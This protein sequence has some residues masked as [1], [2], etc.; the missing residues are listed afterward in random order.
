M[1]TLRLINPNNPPNPPRLGD[2]L[3]RVHEHRDDLR[4]IIVTGSCVDRMGRLA[5]GIEER[6]EEFGYVIE[7]ETF[8]RVGYD[9]ARCPNLNHL[10]FQDMD[11]G[12]DE[13]RGIWQEIHHGRFVKEITFKEMNL[14]ANAEVA[15]RLSTTGNATKVHFVSCVIER[16]IAHCMSDYIDRLE[17]RNKNWR[18]SLVVVR[19][20][21][22][23][24]SMLRYNMNGN[25]WDY[26]GIREFAYHLCDLIGVMCIFEGCTLDRTSANTIRH[27][28]GNRNNVD[29]LIIV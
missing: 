10:V 20:V 23:D 15:L 1:P 21:G 18:S 17:H 22:C 25:D 26:D 28:F 16:D 6:D 29:N 13:L 8:S 9:L 24:M 3:R 2:I 12:R 19:F 5:V 14:T 27:V 7:F 11:P 4:K